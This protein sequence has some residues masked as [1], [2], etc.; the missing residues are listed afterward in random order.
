MKRGAKHC[1]EKL[2][3]S[4]VKSV[5]IQ[6]RFRKCIVRKERTLRWASAAENANGTGKKFVSK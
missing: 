3:M 6:N 4:C 1:G 5:F 2:K